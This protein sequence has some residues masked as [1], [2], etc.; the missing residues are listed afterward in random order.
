[1]KVNEGKIDRLV[2]FV[3]GAILLALYLADVVTGTWGTVAL[4]VSIVLL[5]TAATGFCGLY[6]LLGINTCP[7]K[8]QKQ[9]S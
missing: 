4:V 8:Q 5:A 9:Q 6:A 2:R 3:L 1:M 7:V